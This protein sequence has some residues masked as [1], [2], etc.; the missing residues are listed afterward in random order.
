M[1]RPLFRALAAVAAALAAGSAA[2]AQ[3]EA[4]WTASI[5]VG[6][7]GFIDADDADDGATSNLY[8]D[9]DRAQ[10]GLLW[11]VGLGVSSRDRVFGEEETEARGVSVVGWAVFPVGAADLT[12]SADYAREDLDSFEIAAESGPLI[13][14]GD[15]DFVSASARLSRTFGGATR[16]TPSVR[17]GWSQG[18][19][20]FNLDRDRPNAGA[21]DLSQDESGL[22]GSLGLRAARDLSP[23]V[24]AYAGAAL[25]GAENEASA[26]SRNGG[27]PRTSGSD[28]ASVWGDFSAGAIV[29]GERTSLAFDG[30]AT[31]GLDTDEFGGVVTVS[32]EF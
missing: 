12:L 18:E 5:G 32:R 30:F 26:W 25:V 29:F 2:G 17:I 6:G 1:P 7:V 28:D 9:I 31:A 16:L 19:T 3:E 23:A 21:V 15:S 24:T 11:G 4:V 14:D 22:V 20:A 27:A 10:D 13:V 8:L